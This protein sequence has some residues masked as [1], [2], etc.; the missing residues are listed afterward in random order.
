MSAIRYAGWDS[1]P[2]W[3]PQI[4]AL[5]LVR[6]Y[7]DST[8]SL[9]ALVRMPTGTGKTGVISV[10]AR[11]LPRFK[12]VLLI[13]PW[14]P[15]RE[16]LERDVR[17][18][19]W[20]H[21]YVDPG[22]WPKEF[23]KILPSNALTSIGELNGKAAVFVCTIPALQSMHAEWSAEFLALRDRV[24]L[25][26]VDEG[27]R[28]PA[29]KWAEAVRALGSPT[30]LLSATP[31]RNDHKLFN[32]DPNY[33]YAFSHHEAVRQRYI[34]E[35]VFRESTFGENAKTFVD[36]LLKFYRG[37]FQGLKPSAV[38][39]HRVI[40][41]CEAD[42]E[43]TRIASLLKNA[44]EKV[45]AVHERY[46]DDTDDSAFRKTVPSPDDTDAT[47]W[48]HQQKLIEGIDDPRFSL[49]AIFRPFRTFEM[50]VRSCSKSVEL[51]AIR[52]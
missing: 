5:T 37:E 41:R 15:L 29:P 9:S 45:I 3:S 38:K 28:E 35:V 24:D 19:F 20:A 6:E 7:L 52:P 40:V 14:A 48:V 39:D 18:R 46:E 51:Y 4:D 47:F 36:A 31:Y 43:I 22:K 2:L 10:L 25:V 32:V 21:I 34:R 8:S 11:C 27:H 16:Q 42:G 17:E 12:N 30:V 23:R 33:I 26:V 44:G 1:L 49:L 50:P 13:T